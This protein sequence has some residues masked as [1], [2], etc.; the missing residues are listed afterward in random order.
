M[1]HCRIHT[2][3]FTELKLLLLGLLLSPTV[4]AN[5]VHHNLQVRLDPDQSQ[6]S[7]ND[8]IQLPV[9]TGKSIDFSLHSDLVVTTQDAELKE[10][11]KSTH[12]HI[13]HY[14][15]SKLPKDRRVTL[16]Y[17]GI[18]TTDK[19]QDQFEMPEYILSQ[20]GVYLDSTSAWFP[21]FRTHP[22]MTFNLQVEALPNWEIISQGK[23]TT[24][25]GNFHFVMPHPQ[26]EIYLLG[27]SFKRYQQV[28]DDIELV[29]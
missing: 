15:L 16:S 28:Q 23:R 10:L 12:G 4:W 11:D 6:I 7:V 24:Q 17:Q 19:A 27:G 1:H 25:N 8:Q 18:I 21:Q 29:V 3:H 20:D 9:D 14:R 26:D 22:W 2:I 13:R 5:T